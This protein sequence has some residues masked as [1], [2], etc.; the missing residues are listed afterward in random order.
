MKQHEDAVRS[1]FA[2]NAYPLGF[3]GSVMKHFHPD[4]VFKQNGKVAVN[5][6]EQLSSMFQTYNCMYRRPYAIVDIKN[7]ASNGNT[8]FVEWEEECHHY[9][10]EK[11]EKYNIFIGRLCAV[12]TVDDEG[13]ITGRSDYY[14]QSEE[15][16]FGPAMPIPT[17]EEV[18]AFNSA[19]GYD[20]S[21]ASV[22]FD[23]AQNW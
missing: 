14:N 5:S 20:E 17:E 1:F 6:R 16:K 10:K 8:V 13:M 12:F 18:K 19:L 23:K 21:K 15:Y 4:V 11:G 9:N 22:D 7:I 2:D 3:V